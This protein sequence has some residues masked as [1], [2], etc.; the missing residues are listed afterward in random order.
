M[1]QLSILGILIFN[2]FLSSLI[3]YL[4]SNVSGLQ[5][6]KTDSILSVLDRFIM[7][8]ICSVLVWGNVTG[9]KLSIE[10]FVLSQTVAYLITAIIAFVLVLYK[11]GRFRFNFDFRFFRVFLRKSYPYALLIL[12]M[13]F[14]NRVDSV[15]LE[16]LLPDGKEQAGIYAQAYR[17]LEAASMLPYLFSI[18]LLPMFARMIKKNEKVDE[19]G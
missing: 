19:L 10:W 14:Y 7:I 15:M 6:F 13:A 8:A 11:A 17:I 5:L 4:R 9:F 3:L 1:R 18:I 12:L 16:R 2:Q